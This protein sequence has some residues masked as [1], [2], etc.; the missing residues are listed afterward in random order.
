MQ[1][2]AE[3]RAKIKATLLLHYAGLDE[4]INAGIPAFETALKAAGK[5]NIRSTSIEGANHA[6]NNDTRGAL[7]QGGP[8]TSP[9]AGRSGSSPKAILSMM[10]SALPAGA[11]IRRRGPGGSGVLSTPMYSSIVVPVDLAEV[12]I[13]QPAI[14]AAVRLA[15]QSGGRVTLVNVVPIMPVMMLDTVPVSYEAEV[16]EKAQVGHDEVAAMVD[17]PRD[18]VPAVVKIGGVYH[19]VLDVATQANADLVWS[20]RHR[21]AMVTIYPRLQRHGYRPALDLLGAGRARAGADRLQRSNR[22]A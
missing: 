2:T 8:P 17:L 22:L 10:R 3:R 13:S 12:E 15:K 1:P 9:G 20:A 18:R 7:R 11:E 4:R 5:S 14:A 6:F 21:P 19:E 16:A